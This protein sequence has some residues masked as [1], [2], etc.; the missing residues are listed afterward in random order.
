MATG[1]ASLAAVEQTPTP[2]QAAAIWHVLDL[3]D[4][5]GSTDVEAQWAR[6]TGTTVST[7]DGG[8]PIWSDVVIVLQFDEGR[9][10]YVW[11]DGYTT[12]RA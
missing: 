1:P 5:D 10:W 2:E 8:R 9:R 6:P 4:E 12:W 11:P 7:A 3:C